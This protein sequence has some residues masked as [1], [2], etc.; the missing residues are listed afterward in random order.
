MF[1]TPLWF[2]FK[3][4]FTTLIVEVGLFYFLVSKRPVKLL[5][6]AVF[7]VFTHLSLNIFFS[8]MLLTQIGYNIY[9]YLFGEVMV[10]LIEAVLYYVSKCIPKFKRAVLLS[11]VFN[12]ASIIVG[13]MI[14]LILK[15]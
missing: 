12:I 14:N 10:T 2:Y 15:I 7:N 13:Q 6:A 5:S 11:V 4:L 1:F 3:Q 9:V 8:Y